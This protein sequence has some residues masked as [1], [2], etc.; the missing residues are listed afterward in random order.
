MLIESE[1]RA[2]RERYFSF[3]S[4]RLTRRLDGLRARSRRIAALRL[5]IVIVGLVLAVATVMWWNVTAAWSVVGLSIAVFIGV[6]VI[7]RRLEGWI[8]TLAVWR[9]LK[10]DALARMRLDWENLPP[11]R[12]IEL[13][14]KSLARDLDLTGY[15]SLHHLLDTTISRHGTQRLAEWLTQTRPD[16]EAIHARQNIVR[17]LVLRVRFRERFRLTFQRV[18]KRELEGDNL[19][20]WLKTEFPSRRIA[21]ML[22]IAAVF[23]VVNIVLFALALFRNVP[24]Y[25]ILSLV[26]YAAFYYWN[27]SALETVLGAV[28][29]VNTEL[30]KFR[31]LLRYLERASYANAEHLAA[32]CAPLRVATNPPSQQLRQI[33][34]VTVAVGLRSNPLLALVLNLI[35]PWDFLFAFLADRQRTRVAQSLPQWVEVIHELDALCA[36]ANFAYLNPEAHLP[37]IRKDAKPVLRA[38]ALGHPL[39]PADARVCNDFTIETLGEVEILTGSNMAGKS[40]FLKTV[41]VNLC[42]AFAGA[43][44][45]AAELIAAPFRLHTCIRITDSV[46]DGF[47]YF[48]AEVKCLRALLEELKAEDE[49]PLL[50]LV[51]EIFRGTNNRERLIGSRAYLHALLGAQGVGLIATHDLELANLAGENGH[52]HNFHFRDEVSDGRLVFDYRLREG[53]SPTTNAL[54]IMELEG[55]PIET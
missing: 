6:V 42:L 26:A 20:E 51:D 23:V 48:Y 24:P 13:R 36:L 3:A 22:P 7:H 21:W 19:L 40:T 1:T 5:A 4:E 9:G 28:V 10:L 2:A 33:Q 55:L 25:W 30:E 14:D 45:I 46:V 41:G 39:L 31:A 16:L 43:P 44:V 8:E 18:L 54:K 12:P 53:I 47:S 15:R 32:L 29:R 11:P 35:L 52:A 50:Y 37:D 17:E 38:R 49:L 27:Q 34:L